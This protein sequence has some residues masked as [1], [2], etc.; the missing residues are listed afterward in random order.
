MAGARGGGKSQ[1]PLFFFFEQLMLPVLIDCLGTV[2]K[3][4]LYKKNEGFSS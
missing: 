2:N 1:Y 4:S 3:M